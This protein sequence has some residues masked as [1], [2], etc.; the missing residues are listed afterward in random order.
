MEGCASADPGTG[1]NFGQTNPILE[2]A[3]LVFRGGASVRGGAVADGV[4]MSKNIALQPR[5]PENFEV[6]GQF[7]KFGADRAGRLR[8]F[9]VPV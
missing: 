1:P 9:S 5:G 3:A 6:D 8:D 4:E 2:N 7:G